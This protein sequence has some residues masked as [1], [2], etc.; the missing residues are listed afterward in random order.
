MIAPIEYIEDRLQVE[1]EVEL[2][3]LA[4]FGFKSPDQLIVC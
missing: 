4:I 2:E 1:L 3:S